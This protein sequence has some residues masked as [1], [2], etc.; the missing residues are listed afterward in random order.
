MSDPDLV[1]EKSV[2]KFNYIK[3][4]KNRIVLSTGTFSSTE[5]TILMRSVAAVTLDGPAKY[6]VITTTGG[7]VHRPRFAAGKIAQA[8]RDAILAQL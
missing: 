3:V 8:A 4:Y 2:T 1:Y 6:L 7:E 5:T